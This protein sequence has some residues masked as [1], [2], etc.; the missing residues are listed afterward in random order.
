M[1]DAGPQN[2]MSLQMQHGQHGGV[3]WLQ[4]IL[5]QSHGYTV[6]SGYIRTFQGGM[7]FDLK[8]KSVGNPFA[9]K[10]DSPIVLRSL[11]AQNFLISVLHGK[12]TANVRGITE[13][14]ELLA[15]GGTNAPRTIQEVI[16]QLASHLSYWDDRVFSKYLSGADLIELKFMKR[17]NHED[18][19]L[20]GV[21]LN[22]EILMLSIQLTGVIRSLRD[23]EKSI[24]ELLC[25]LRGNAARGL[26]EGVKKNTRETIKE[27]EAV[28]R[29]L[30]RIEK[31]IQSCVRSWSKNRSLR[32]AHNFKVFGVC[33]LVLLV[34][35]K[36]FAV[37]V[38]GIPGA[39]DT[40]YAFALF[41]GLLVLLGV[42][43][44]TVGLRNGSWS[45]DDNAD[46]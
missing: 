36:L 40:P 8:G 23:R 30:S 9:D 44:F 3:M 41:C 4:I 46:I 42:V 32:V 31:V 34:I 15:A 2:T 27:Q 16:A 43:L 12:K 18:M 21:I 25:H 35:T 17:R 10:D 26:L 14:Q 24:S 38:D 7:L 33:C 11:T 20:L 29:Q 6:L 45:L 22:R 13:V 28:F 1:E 5:L 37:N 39:K 19:N